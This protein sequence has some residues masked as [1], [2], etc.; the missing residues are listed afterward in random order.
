MQAIRITPTGFTVNDVLT[1][2]AAE[3]YA[4]QHSFFAN[5][6]ETGNCCRLQLDKRELRRR[7]GGLFGSD[8]K[9]GSVNVIT[10]NLPRIGYLANTEE[11]FFERLDKLMDLARDAHEIK[12]K[13]IVSLTR[14]GLFPYTA[15]Y[16]ENYNNYFSTIG[17]VGMN[18]ACQNL[19]GEEYGIAS[20]KGHAFAIR[21]LDHMR[22]RISTYQVETGN[23]YNLESTPAE[24]TAYRL[25]KHDKKRYPD[26]I[27]AGKTDPYY[28]NSS[29]LPVNYT[30]DPWKAIKHQEPLQTR[31]T[32]GT[33]LHIFLGERIDRWQNCRDFVKKVC[34]NSRLPY[35]SISP[36]YSICKNGHG[37]LSGTQESCPYCRA[38]QEASYRSK[39][40]ELKAE[41]EKLL[42]SLAN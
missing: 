22:E 40:D 38:E 1:G 16:I 32:G 26:I 33:V 9:T 12:R 19:F 28:T 35:I 37:Y 15:A 25:A 29:N 39:L 7:G 8:E 11:E 21:V 18:E 13:T 6:L 24:S 5:G 17:L 23:L 34:E 10:I 30:D 20:E 4:S 36:T 31:Y 42:A 3:S 41:R 2:K 27:T 14:N